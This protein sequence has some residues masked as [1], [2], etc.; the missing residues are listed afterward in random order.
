MKKINY[1]SLIVGIM[2]LAFLSGCDKN[3]P[4][5]GRIV[6]QIRPVSETLLP[7]I[8]SYTSGVITEGEPIVVR[9]KYP[10]T[11][12]VKQG[13]TLP[14]KLFSFT[15]DLKGKAVWLDEN[16]V[17][18]K[19][20]KID[21]SKQYVCRFKVAE[22][23]DVAATE[24]LE[25]GFGVRRQSFNLVDVYPICQSADAMDYLL[26]VQFAAP[27]KFEDAEK[28]FDESFAKQY[29]VETSFVNDYYYS[30][31]I[32][33]LQRKDT[34]YDIEINLNGKNIGSDTKIKRNV[35]VYAKDKFMPIDFDVEK[36]SGQGTLFFTQPLKEDQN[37]N[38]LVYFSQQKLAAKYGIQ[39]NY[40][41]FYFDKSSLY[42]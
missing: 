5:N 32:K 39:D 42:S 19:Y 10:N 41:T 25:F 1:L 8:D 3:K 23:L 16:T 18:F 33:S 15:P 30:Y 6:E 34:D 36:S 17:A 13:E 27:V 9:F 31:T 37:L 38:G 26:Y 22:M 11:L 29:Q 12:K 20:D 21:N 4:S 7:L 24:T 40:I 28:I 14:A 2:L 35:T